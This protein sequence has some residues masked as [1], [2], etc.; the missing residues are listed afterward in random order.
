MLIGYNYYLYELKNENYI[1]QSYIVEY[2]IEFLFKNWSF[3]VLLVN[4]SN[5]NLISFKHIYKL[6]PNVTLKNFTPLNNFLLDKEFE[7]PTVWLYF[8]YILNMHA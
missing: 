4:Y 5:N 6:T 2:Y 3:I 1:Y 8:L 7:N